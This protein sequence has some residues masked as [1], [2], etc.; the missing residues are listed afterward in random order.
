MNTRGRTVVGLLVGKGWSR[1]EAVAHVKGLSDLG[2]IAAYDQLTLEARGQSV[3]PIDTPVAPPARAKKVSYSLLL[4]P[5]ML[6]AFKA[7]ADRDG[8]SASQFI[9]T[10]IAKQLGRVK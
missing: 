4:P 8:S 2:L 7:A 10:A 5:E 3:L 9:R 1:S 6:E